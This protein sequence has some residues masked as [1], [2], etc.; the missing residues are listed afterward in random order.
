[1]KPIYCAGTRMVQTRSAPRCVVPL[2][3][4]NPTGSAL[5]LASG[6]LR[7]FMPASLPGEAS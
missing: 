7:S 2:R 1:M 3:A 5:T 6:S 4:S